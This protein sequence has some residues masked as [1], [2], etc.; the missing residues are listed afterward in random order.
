MGERYKINPGQ[1]A[2]YLQSVVKLDALEKMTQ[3]LDR[4]LEDSQRIMMEIK[5]MYDSVSTVPENRPDSDN[6]GLRHEDI[7]NFLE[8]GVPNLLMPGMSGDTM[9]VD[10]DNVIATMK[11]YAEDLKK[12]FIAP[13]PQVPKPKEVADLDLDQYAQSLDQLGK[14][15]ANI[16]LNKKDDLNNR[17][18]EL[19][20]KLSQLCEDVSMFTKVRIYSQSK[21]VYRNTNLD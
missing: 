13:M 1:F 16:K 8:A 3:D 9:D 19:E 17:S 14:R 20:G 6:N 21:F 12:N 5:T 4:E 10:I 18:V 2:E 15:L 11:S 7:S